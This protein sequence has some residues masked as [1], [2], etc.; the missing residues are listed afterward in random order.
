MPPKDV[1]LGT[2]H[3]YSH[4]IASGGLTSILVCLGCLVVV[5][6]VVFFFFGRWFLARKANAGRDAAVD[7]LR[8]KH[9]E[10]ILGHMRALETLR[11]ERE[12]LAKRA[13][14]VVQSWE[15]Q[16]PT[17][18][19]PVEGPG[20]AKNPKKKAVTLVEDLAE[21]I[22]ML[23]REHQLLLRNTVAALGEHDT[24]G[25]L[26][27]DKGNAVWQKALESAQRETEK[28]MRA[29]MAAGGASTCEL[30]PSSD[31]DETG[32]AAKKKK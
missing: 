30:L 18:S 16:L 10:E 27:V 8:R 24:A 5:L 3:F 28:K 23:S 9:Y 19:E 2:H 21:E 15:H 32:A 25:V 20:A 26:K 14:R 17:M 6:A 4:M 13:L 29:A 22:R 12:L 31:D 1:K 7:E 11:L